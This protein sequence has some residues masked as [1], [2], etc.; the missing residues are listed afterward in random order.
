MNSPISNT[1]IGLRP[2][3]SDRPPKALAPIRMPN[4]LAAPTMP[5]CASVRSYSLAISG[6]ATPVRNTTRP[7]KNL[8]ATES[9]QIRCCISVSRDGGAVVPSAHSGDSSI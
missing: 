6:R 4:R 7:S 1:N 9:H 3:R 2:K 5:C 8:P